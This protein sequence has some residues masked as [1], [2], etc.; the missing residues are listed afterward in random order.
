[1]MFSWWCTGCGTCGLSIL[2][3]RKTGSLRRDRVGLAHVHILYSNRPG[4]EGTANQ[5]HPG[6]CQGLAVSRDFDTA[7]PQQTSP[8]CVQQQ[9]TCNKQSAPKW[10]AVDQLR[11]PA[12][13]QTHSSQGLALPCTS[14][15]GARHAC[16]VS[17]YTNATL[18]RWQQTQCLQAFPAE[19]QPA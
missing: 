16:T 6:W 7:L 14:P 9:A 10:D 17:L 8:I 18:R 5:H 2:Q 4:A 1:M 3:T 15:S 13:S 11:T 19:R 12:A